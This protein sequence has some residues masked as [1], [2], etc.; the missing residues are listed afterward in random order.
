[1]SAFFGL[2]VVL[3]G[4]SAFSLGFFVIYKAIM[5]RVSYFRAEKRGESVQNVQ[6]SEFFDDV[7]TSKPL[8]KNR[9]LV[10]LCFVVTGFLLFSL[11]LLMNLDTLRTIATHQ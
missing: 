1:M 4:L 8:P 5:F 3:L 10:R 9:V 6:L 11:Y 2:V 7:F